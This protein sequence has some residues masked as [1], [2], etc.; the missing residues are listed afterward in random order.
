[1]RKLLTG[2]TLLIITFELY[3]PTAIFRV[4]AQNGATATARTARTTTAQ[5]LVTNQSGHRLN[6][7]GLIDIPT[8]MTQD[9]TGGAGICGSRFNLAN[10]AS[11]TLKLT[12]SANNMT[13]NIQ[14]GPRIC[15]TPNNRV[16]CS[17]PLTQADKLNITKQTSYQSYAYVVR[18]GEQEIQRCT[19]DSTTG[20]FTA[21]V[22]ALTDGDLA[23]MTRPDQITLTN[24][25]NGV[26]ITNP[27]IGDV[28]NPVFYCDI[29]T[30]GAL[31]N[32][33][34]AQDLNGEENNDFVE[35]TG[36]QINKTGT[37]AYIALFDNN[38]IA[39]CPIE[40]ATHRFEACTITDFDGT[41]QFASLALNHANTKLYFATR[42]GDLATVYSCD[43][44]QSTGAIEICAPIVT[45][46]DEFDTVEGLTVSQNDRY[47][48]AANQAGSTGD[49][50]FITVCALDNNGDFTNDDCDN[51]IVSGTDTVDDPHEIALNPE[52]TIAYIAS[53]N[54][55]NTTLCNVRQSDFHLTDCE[56]AGENPGD[57]QTGIVI[58]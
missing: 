11:C 16:F 54:K 32:C 48:F 8:G 53:T 5:Y 22:A 15:H 43:I 9:T 18:R 35:P 10:N 50:G 47:L 21:C 23:A 33:I 46:S 14:D 31:E 41:D 39:V 28:N 30:N 40:T 4:E 20:N 26:Y 58:Y 49:D 44:N 56:D 55:A 1:M 29:G 34:D 3:A 27:I 19:I 2:L 51:A 25:G 45:D 6:G 42:E 13:N 57:D 7:N 52:N 17:D 24:D 38:E 12:F 36:I 37:I